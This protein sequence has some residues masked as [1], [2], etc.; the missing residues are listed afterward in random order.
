MSYIDELG[1]K[2][3]QAAKQSAVLR[4][5]KKNDILLEIADLLL[6]SEEEIVKANTLDIEAAQKNGMA[7][8]MVDRLTLT[9]DR[10]AG[11]AKGVEQV[12]ALADPVGRVTGGGTLK[13][14]LT[15][16]KKTVPLGVIGI[17]FESRPNVTVDAGCLCLKAGNAVILR[18]GSDAINSNK[19]LV[20]IMRKAAENHGVNPDI[21]QLVED[22]S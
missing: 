4:E 2:A 8:A 10:I 7:S 13:N 11:M 9:H 12:A 14:G 20:G 18:G 16:V 17:I 1:A 5:T 6:K 15:I 19:C 3:K 22:T 21:V